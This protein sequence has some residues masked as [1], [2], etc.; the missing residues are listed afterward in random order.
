MPAAS[1]SRISIEAHLL[2]GW[3]EVPSASKGSRSQGQGSVAVNGGPD[4]NAPVA[5]S[6]RVCGR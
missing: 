1:L 5:A 4:A 2:Q 6:V 3:L